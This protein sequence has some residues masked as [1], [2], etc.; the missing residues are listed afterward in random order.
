[1]EDDYEIVT[2][3]QLMVKSGDLNLVNLR[4]AT[5]QPKLV[6]PLTMTKNAS[7]ASLD[8]NIEKLS[9]V[10]KVDYSYLDERFQLDDNDP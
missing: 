3:S 6:Q 10:D 5:P 9:D 1:M 7:L 8:S 4:G 2:K